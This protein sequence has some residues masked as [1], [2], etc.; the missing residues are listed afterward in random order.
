MYDRPFHSF[1][2][3]GGVPSVQGDS[4]C[5][6][7]KNVTFWEAL[8]LALCCTFDGYYRMAILHWVFPLQKG[9]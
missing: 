6:L 8:S 5:W 3:G 9:I 4:D 7:S 1:I 2:W